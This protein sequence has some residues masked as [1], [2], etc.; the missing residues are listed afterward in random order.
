MTRSLASLSVI[1]RYGPRLLVKPHAYDG[2]EEKY[3]TIYSKD[4]RYG[5][6]FETDGVKVTR[7][8]VGTAEAVQY[9]EGCA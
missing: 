6:R 1:E 3:L 5:V 8:Y 9:I 2:P 7:Y 4:K